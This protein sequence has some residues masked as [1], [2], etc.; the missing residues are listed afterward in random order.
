[1]R[2]NFG[3]AVC[4]AAAACVTLAGVAWADPPQLPR[5]TRDYQYWRGPSEKTPGP[6][7]CALPDATDLVVT[8][9]RWPD[10]S[11]L[12]RFGE[13]AVRLSGAKTEQDKA[14]AVWM[15]LRRVKSQTNGDAPYDPY[16]PERTVPEVYD[17]IKIL[18]VYGAHWCSGLGR[19]VAMIWRAMGYEGHAVHRLSH[20]M[21]GLYYLDADGGDRC[22]L[23]DC[24]FGGFTTDRKGD[25]VLGP[26]DFSTDYYQWMYPWYFGEPWPM[27]THRVELSMRRGESLTRKWGNWGKPVEDNFDNDADVKTR[28]PSEKGPYPITYGNGLWTYTP[29]LSA[30]EWADGLAEPA[31]GLADGKGLT[32]AKAGVP[33]VAVWHFRS[34]Y[35]IAEAE[36]DLSAFRKS[37]ADAI[38]LS[39]SVDD[40]RSYQ[41]CWEAPGGQTGA[42]IFKVVLDK[43]FTVTPRHPQAPKDLGS[44]FAQY[45]YRIRLELLAKDAPADCRVDAIT[46]K[47]TVQQAIRSLPQL[48]P[49]KNAIAVRGT[50][51]AGTAVRITYTWDD[52][53]GKDR[54]NVTV[55]DKLPYS[56]EIVAAGGKWEDVVCKDLLIETI[57]ADGQGPRTLVKETPSPIEKLPPLPSAA[58]TRTRWIRELHRGKA[59]P[60]ISQVNEWMDSRGKYV[61]TGL[62]WASELEAPE[63]FESVRKVAFDT[64]LCKGGTIK[65]L[66][67]LALYNS[68]RAKARPLLLQIVGDSECKTGWKFDPKDPVVAG[69][70]WISGVAIISQMAAES[71]WKEFAQPLA[72]A[73]DSRFCNDLA[74]MQILRA[75][76][77]IAEPGDKAVTEAVRKSLA[78]SYPYM[79]VEA[80]RAA[81]CV[82]DTASIPRLRELLDHPFLVVRAQAAIALGRLGDTASAP[83][84]RESLTHIRKVEL[85]DHMKYNTVIYQDEHM[86]AAAAEGLGL[87]K[88]KDS[89][90]AL[91]DAL[92]NEPVPWV[93]RKIEEAI[94][95]VQ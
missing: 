42:R 25:R 47:T 10:C 69:G 33:A 38:R 94:K 56:Y 16:H 89:L 63:T 62:V 49:G 64:E 35:L 87:M 85:L 32:P 5:V 83:T 60:K 4:L 80:A 51:R 46:F 79:L 26:D 3:S 66:A 13:D 74:R 75:L 1:M 41:P 72:A 12:R 95:A 43:K 19:T 7:L 21:A 40:G 15:W 45:A 31:Q 36:I 14:L 93:R 54:T 82:H 22:H 24:N 6:F 8:C 44:P 23:F 68:D 48:W 39:L 17:P 77:Q 37:D 70:H 53:S 11:D 20:G 91:R 84:L 52:P 90:P 58:D 2:S 67:L 18:N 59:P 9:D 61:K 78:M 86:R 28:Q 50:L 76:A 27:P 57:A 34:P 55:T 81:G 73:T 71:D 88:D 29:D 92:A 30:R 65:E